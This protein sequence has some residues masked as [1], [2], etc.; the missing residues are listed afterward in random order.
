MMVKV[1]SKSP[2]LLGK[3]LEWQKEKINKNRNITAKRIESED[4]WPS[5]GSFFSINLKMLDHSPS[6]L[7]SSNSNLSETVKDIL[8]NSLISPCEP[9]SNLTFTNKE[10]H[11]QSKDDLKETRKRLIYSPLK[12]TPPKRLRV[13]NEAVDL[14][15]S[16]RFDNTMRNYL[17]P[18]DSSTPNQPKKKPSSPTSSTFDHHNNDTDIDFKRVAGN[19]VI[20]LRRSQRKSS[21]F[22]NMNLSTMVDL[23]T[24]RSK[25][26]K[27]AKKSDESLQLKANRNEVSTPK[28]SARNN[29]SKLNSSKSLS[30]Q[31]EVSTPKESAKN[32]KSKLNSNKSLSNQEEVLAPKESAKNNK[33]KLNSNKSLS[34]QEEVS[35]PKESAK[36]NK[37]K[38]NSNKSLSNQEVLAPKE[39]AKNNKSKLN[40][41]K[42]LSNQEE[43]LAPK[44]SAKNN[45]SKLNSNK[46]LSNQE[47]VLAPKESAKNN[48]SKLNSNKSLSNQEEVLAPKE[49]AKNNKS[50]LNSNKSLSNQEE[51]LAP[52][53]SANNNKS[54]LNSNKSLS[55][56]EEVLAPKESAKNNKSKLNSKSDDTKRTSNSNQK[57][58]STHMEYAK[59]NKSI[60]NSILKAN[61]KEVLTPKKSAKN[62]KSKLNSSISKSGDN[63]RTS[64][65]YR[66]KRKLCMPNRRRSEKACQTSKLNKTKNTNEL[67]T[68]KNQTKTE[69]DY[70]LNN[71]SEVVK[72][73]SKTKSKKIHILSERSNIQSE[74]TKSNHLSGLE[75][76]NLTRT[77]RDY[78]IDKQ[79]IENMAT[80]SDESENVNCAS[81]CSSKLKKKKSKNILP[82]K[83]LPQN[84][85]GPFIQNEDEQSSSKLP[86]TVRVKMHGQNIMANLNVFC[87]FWK[88]GSH[89]SRNYIFCGS[90]S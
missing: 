54:K 9:V 77:E 67:E 8:P 58:V 63:K 84:L 72:N 34:N 18:F 28:E 49:S 38:L 61:E 1:P 55:N 64:K 16:F 14:E 37:S 48:K 56:Q 62:N 12:G 88:F 78:A 59:N 3:K 46:S 27:T 11:L 30:N 89:Y 41:D 80:D 51:V 5:P 17:R 23:C 36:N 47:E 73:A 7:T 70:A 31:E 13:E 21:Q 39:S 74:N 71:E 45:K 10:K 15:S 19:S 22:I 86:E 90:W 57:E 79:I 60:M 24:N 81:N 20:Q 52:K 87:T 50:K 83:S 66:R 85:F 25:F 2:L 42:S 69:S 76:K 26:D 75:L 43:V 68:N 4:K 82:K 29:K 40:S 65:P 53:E 44:E 32:N 35:T 6:L 33:S